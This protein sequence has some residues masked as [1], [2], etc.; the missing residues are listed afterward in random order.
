LVLST[1]V[2]NKIQVSETTAACLIEAGKEH[3]LTPREDSVKAKGK[4]TMITYWLNISSTKSNTMATASQTVSSDQDSH[5]IAS[6]LCSEKVGLS[7]DWIYEMLQTHIKVI[8]LA[9]MAATSVLIESQKHTLIYD[10]KGIPMDEV[11]E[12]I[13]LPEYKKVA[14]DVSPKDIEMPPIVVLQLRQYITM[15]AKSYRNN[16]FH[17][18][19]HA[20]HVSM[21]VSKLLMRV[22]HPN[23][24]T[25]KKDNVTATDLNHQMHDDS[26]GITS[27]PITILAIVLSAVVHDVDHRGVSN[28]Q[29]I[30]EEKPLAELYH[31]KSVAEQNSLDI[32]WS[33][34]LSS[35]FKELR[36]FIFTTQ[37]EVH[38]F[39]QVLVNTVLATDIM[40]KELNDLRCKRWNRAFGSGNVDNEQFQRNLRATIVI[41]HLIQASDVAHTMQHWHVYRKW[42]RLLFQEMFMAYQTGRMDANPYEF[43]YQGEL[44]FFDNYIIPLAK[45]LKDCNV[46]GVSSDE[47]LNYAEQNRAEWK[48]RG[49]EI[50]NEMMN[51]YMQELELIEQSVRSV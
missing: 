33:L 10:A 38:R 29:L 20:C 27:D 8:I 36:G 12:A 21:S 7:I 4:G 31:N 6:D 17:N 9:R 39:R 48:E 37:D 18:F 41:E 24:A 14:K 22:V 26:Y 1:G 15:I 3:W 45:K 25:N 32:A 49:V 35:Q 13:T 30:K 50:V 42:N 5:I 44:A 40:D 2:K 51:E 47:Y 28:I 23:L 19:E 16:L 43:W 34:L 46:F 11:V